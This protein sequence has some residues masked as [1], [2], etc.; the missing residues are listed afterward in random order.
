M[1]DAIE[2]LMLG[3]TT[4]IATHRLSTI[5]RADVIF[6]L[7][8]GDLLEQGSHDELMRRSGMYARMINQ[9]SGIS[10]LIPVHPSTSLDPL[11]AGR[12]AANF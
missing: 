6:V 5:R 8:D 9:Q 10:E 4:V 2:R 1:Q 7:G 11:H 12:G 3:R